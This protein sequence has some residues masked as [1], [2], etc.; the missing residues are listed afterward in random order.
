VAVIVPKTR[1]RDVGRR[2][3][4]LPKIKIIIQK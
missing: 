1:G 3:C 2:L 4:P